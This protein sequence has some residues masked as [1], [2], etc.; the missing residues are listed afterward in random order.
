MKKPR[1]KILRGFF[2]GGL[3]V[4]YEM[5]LVP[6]HGSCAGR[7]TLDCAAV[8]SRYAILFPSVRMVC[9]PSRSRR[10]SSGVKPCVEFQYWLETTGI[11][12]I[13]KYLFSL[14]NVELAPPRRQ[15]T[16]H[17]AGLY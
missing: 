6:I 13:V 3:P 7:G 4:F 12:Q 15:L 5:K 8:F 9:N 10:T 14:S 16:T 17:A 2:F 1:G 11:W